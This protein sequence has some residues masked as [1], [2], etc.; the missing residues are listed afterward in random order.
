MIV[1]G[2]DSTVT[3]C[4][5]QPS[6]WTTAHSERPEEDECTVFDSKKKEKA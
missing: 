6:E 4:R 3:L 5:S 1:F 2:Y